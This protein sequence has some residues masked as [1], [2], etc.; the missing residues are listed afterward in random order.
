MLAFTSQK[1]AYVFR[2]VQL[3]SAVQA[4]NLYLL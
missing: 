1:N 2:K 3:L 4:N